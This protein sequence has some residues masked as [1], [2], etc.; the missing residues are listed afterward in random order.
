WT[1]G[2]CPGSTRS[3]P[4]SG[5]AGRDPRG[6]TVQPRCIMIRIKFATDQERVQANYLLATKSVVRRL[7]G[8]VF[9]VT[10]PA[11]KLL[12]DHQI[13]YQVLPIPEPSGSD[14]EVRNP[15]TVE[16]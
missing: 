6:R 1:S 15:L 12:D 7:R 8:Q 11:L 13:S 3:W 16:L 14:E 9:E 10:E 2:S 4:R 5:L